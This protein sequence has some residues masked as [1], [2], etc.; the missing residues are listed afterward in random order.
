MA[1]EMSIESPADF[2][3]ASTGSH[4]ADFMEDDAA[5]GSDFLSSSRDRPAKIEESV[6]ESIKNKADQI[7]RL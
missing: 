5:N 6:S 2:L 3:P 7:A 1:E 4:Q